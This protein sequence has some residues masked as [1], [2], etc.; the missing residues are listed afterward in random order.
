[1]SGRFI[2]GRLLA[3]AAALTL[4]ALALLLS[5]ALPAGAGPFAQAAPTATAPGILPAPG[6]GIVTVPAPTPSLTPFGGIGTPVPMGD[7][8]ASDGGILPTPTATLTPTPTPSP[9]F[10]L[11]LMGGDRRPD[12]PANFFRTDV[13]MLVSL[14]RTHQQIGVLSIP[15]DLYVTIPGYQNDRIN[16]A[17]A[18]GQYSGMGGALAMQT[19]SFNFGIPVDAYVAFD[20]AAFIALIDVIDGV[21]VVVEQPIADPLY[22]NMS[23]GYEPFYLEAGPQHLDGATALKYVR[24]RHNS[25]DRERMRRQQQVVAAVRDKI[26]TLNLTEAL[27]DFGPALWVQLRQNIDTDLTLDEILRLGVEISA[28]PEENYAYGVLSY[29]YVYA[30]MIGDQSVLMPDFAAIRGLVAQVFG[31]PTYAW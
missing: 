14:D 1:M 19:I 2:P 31:T 12:E 8:P 26:G 20:F 28:V 11:L 16:T 5:G 23:Y 13:M 7:G 27:V 4:L 22:P 17:Y 24:S 6:S 15:R 21:D 25:D 3:F 9:R 10:T 30:T 18:V 29:P